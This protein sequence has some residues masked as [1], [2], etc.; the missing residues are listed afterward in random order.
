MKT[1]IS[2]IMSDVSYEE[3]ID[4]HHNYAILENHFG[5]N[6]MLHRKGATSAKKDEVGIIPGSQGTYSYIVKGLG[7]PDS[8]MSCSHGAGRK[9]SRK[10]AKSTLNLAE[11]QKK[12]KGIVHSVRNASDLD[13]APGSYKDIDEVMGNQKDL[14]E[15][16]YKLAPMAVLKG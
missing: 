13:E 11:E 1:V 9:L 4:I 10:K 12:L 3:E 14:V 6:V 7:N 16:M 8:F 15:I 5:E 2:Q